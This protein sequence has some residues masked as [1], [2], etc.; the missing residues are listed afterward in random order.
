M[1]APLLRGP[2]LDVGCGE[3]R[4][5]SLLAVGVRW[6]GVD[7]SPT[8]VAANPYRPLVLA[9]MRVLPFRAG[10]FAEVTH[11]W[12][13]YHLADPAAAIAE[14]ARVL[15]PGGRYFACTGA[16]TNDQEIMPEGYPRSSFDAE[17]AVEIV[18]GVFEEVTAEHWDGA[19]FP[20]Q[21]RDA[22]RAYCRHNYIPAERAERV[23]VPLW[24]T[25]R[26]IL[27]RAAKPRTLRLDDHP[28]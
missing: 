8:Q 5:A 19:F 18:A 6:V 9:D 21:T 23:D 14:A 13:L 24:L 10:A 17:E 25:K 15:A 22:V 1:I 3:G 2:I 16:R 7:S 26:G 28:R 27:V 4:L 20:L 12:C 11:L